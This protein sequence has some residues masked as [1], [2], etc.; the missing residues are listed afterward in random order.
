[1]KRS[2]FLLFLLLGTSLLAQTQKQL[3]NELIWASGEFSTDYVYGINSM[4]DGE[5]YTTLDT[6]N[7]EAIVNKY[8]YKAYGE[9]KDVI[10]KSSNLKDEEGKAMAIEGY[11]F[12]DKEKKL[13]ISTQ[14]ESI[15]RHSTRAYYYIY[16]IASKTTK[17]L[18]DKNK[19][20]QRLAEFSPAGDRIAFVRDNN[21][22]IKNLN[23]GV[24]TQITN[25]GEQNSII[26]GATDWVYEE[27]FGI[28]KGFYWSPDGQW[29][30]YYRFDESHV[31]EFQM[32]LYGSLY[33]EQ[34]TF[35]Y[36]KAGE[37][38]S[39]VQVYVRNIYEPLSMPI[40]LGEETDI[41]VPRL[42]WGPDNLL[43]VYRMNRLQ[44][45]MDIIS[46]NF[47]TQY[48]ARFGLKPK[49]IY[50]EKS[51]TYIDI[52]DNLTFLKYENEFIFTSEK[53][54]YN[55]I[56]KKNIRTGKEKQ[57]TQGKWDVTK[58]YGIDEVTNL[59]YFQSAESS[60]INRDI[61]S[62]YLNGKNKEKISKKE[63][64]NDAQFSSNFRYFIN[65]Y[66]NANT[67]YEFTLYSTKDEEPKVLKDNTKLKSKLKEYN[68]PKIEFFT[69]TTSQDIELNG[70]MIKP[71]DFDPNKEY[72]VLMYVYNGPGINTVN[73]SW[74]GAR[75]LWWHYLAQQGYI[76]VSVDGRGTG[77]RGREFKHS[78]YLQLGKYETEDQ[79]EA[80]KYLGSL[81]YIDK[82]R[83]G[84][85]GWSYGG[86]MTSLCMTKG[87]DY[88][89]A[90]IAVAPVTNWRF[91]D[92][93]YTERFMRKPQENGKNYDI[94]SPINHVD[95][96]KGAYLLIHGSADDNVHY[97]NTME[98]VD[99]LVN[100]NKQFDL[101]IYPN[102]NHGIYG[103]NTRLHLYTKMTNFLKENL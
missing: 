7:G 44:N 92:N 62:V 78:T 28:D 3:S 94:N 72:P 48:V 17:P 31:K 55:H 54:G 23:N 71:V 40:P 63:G 4:E 14:V 59:V 66:S 98:M 32:A 24:E 15:Y 18:S 8:A 10:V 25:D 33:P 68:I 26:N 84:I 52:D 12:N 60:P 89:K 9:V 35:K 20:K 53:D 43:C 38:N 65:I 58:V 30:A 93:I 1:M 21:I 75:T 100:A 102:K 90:G 41:Y 88:F 91:Y 87:A 46:Y 97:Q 19:G 95:K 76:V 22:F 57:L 2:T 70:Y 69:F 83:I 6:R 67:P 101:F 61:Y 27:E 45:E 5:H 36:P 79:I 51:E 11:A 50:S 103:G 49:T 29:L 16:D 37:D 42:K 99:A 81:N 13:L 80:A 34:Y 86:Y 77:Y 74:G 39:I 47:G 64:T 85:F 96:L 73:N 82:D 56:Y